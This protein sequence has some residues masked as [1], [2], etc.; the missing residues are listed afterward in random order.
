M[1]P[2]PAPI[3]KKS[4]H[5]IQLM[6]KAGQIVAEVHMLM[7]D[8]IKPGISTYDLD[9]IAEE[10]IAK[11]GAIPTFKG[12]YGFPGSVCTSK[13]DQVVHG[14]PSKECIL[15]EGDIISLDTGATF[16]GLIADSAHTHPV[17]QVTEE[18]QQLLKATRESLYAAIEAFQA[19]NHLEDISG[20]VED[21]NKKY[22][23]GLVRNYGGHGVGHKL[24]EEPFVH[25]YR[26]GNR[27]PELK[28]GNAL[29]IEPM[30]NLGT[31]DVYTEGDQWTVCTV[32]H[33]PSAHFEHTVILTDDGPVAT[34]ELPDVS[35]E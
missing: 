22:G 5:E 6:M 20:A 27:G 16:R 31:D 19:G 35:G 7:R 18:V 25:N 23:Y 34:T 2:F 11:C 17:G 8:A 29:A 24:H 28:V 14:I 3:K 9:K 4:R 21:V 12:L 32:D 1:L 13:N 26:T 10:H 30:F 33:L 15:E